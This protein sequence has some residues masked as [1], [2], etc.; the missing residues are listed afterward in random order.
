MDRDSPAASNPRFAGCLHVVPL[1][2]T[3]M[4]GSST[5]HSTPLHGVH[6][7]RRDTL[8]CTCCSEGGGCVRAA[9]VV[10][11]I[12]NAV[13]LHPREQFRWESQQCT[14]SLPIHAYPPMRLAGYLSEAHTSGE[15]Q[16]LE[17]RGVSDTPSSVLLC[18][19]ALRRSEGTRLQD[20]E[21]AQQLTQA[22]HAAPNAPLS[23][24]ER[25]DPAAC[26]APKDGQEA[27]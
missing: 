14:G 20:L 11:L 1:L 22:V 4:V 3:L 7:T 10:L 16:T 15:T 6:S 9:P 17:A 26:P 5:R 23:V 18:G 21:R 19:K 24:D 8:E 13:Q 25:C 12:R 27:S 2:Q